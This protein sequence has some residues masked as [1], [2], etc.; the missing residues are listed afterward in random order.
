MNLL[1]RQDLA[2]DRAG[3]LGIDV[4]LI[5]LEGVEQDLRP[6]SSRRCCTGTPASW[7]R[8]RAISP[9]ITDSVNTFDPTRTAGWASSAT[10]ASASRMSEAWHHE[11]PAAASSRSWRWALTNWVTN[12]SA[13]S[14][15]ERPQR[16]ALN[17]PAGAHQEDLVAE[18]TG[19]GE[20]MSD[21]DDGLLERSKDGAEVGLELGAD[22]RVESAQGLVEQDDLGVEHERAHQAHALALTARELGGE[23][24]ETILRKSGQLGELG[25]AGR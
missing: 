17:D 20:V 25:R 14:S 11:S 9:R 1:S 12:G 21:H 7:I 24:V 8:S 5:G 13:G 18:P 23:T 15:I 22:H 2:R 10:S 6:P 3:V 4:E 19:L 16:P